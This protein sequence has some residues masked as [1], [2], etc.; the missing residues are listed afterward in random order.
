MFLASNDPIVGYIKWISTI[1]IVTLPWIFL[2]VKK[3]D[4]R[5]ALGLVWMIGIIT[6]TAL[7]LGLLTYHYVGPQFGF[8]HQGNPMDWFMIITGIIS[9]IPFVLAAKNGSLEMPRRTAVLVAVVTLIVM[10]PAIY[11]AVA[12]NIYLQGGGDFDPGEGDYAGEIYTPTESEAWAQAGNIALVV[13]NLVSVII[14]M[15]IWWLSRHANR[16]QNL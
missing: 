11:N 8:R 1:A 2:R 16:N 3:R 15:G 4:A 13:C 6:L 9:V 5:L 7:Y 14:F 12:F 10:G